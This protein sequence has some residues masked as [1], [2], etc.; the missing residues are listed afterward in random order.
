MLVGAISAVYFIAVGLS[1]SDVA[2]I[3]TFQAFIILLAD[4][5]FSYLS[6]RKS[7][8]VSILLGALFSFLWLLFMGMGSSLFE[9]YLAEFFNALSLSLF[10][11]AFIAFL[12]NTYLNNKPEASVKNIIGMYSKYHFFLMGLAALIGSLFVSVGSRNIWIF[13][14]ITMLILLIVFSFL[15][16]GENPRNKERNTTPILK[17]LK[18]IL[19]DIFS[20]RDKRLYAV[21]LLL[22]SLY[23]QIIIQFWQLF[24]NEQDRIIFEQGYIYG[25]LFVGILF[26]QSFAGYIVEKLKIEVTIKIAIIILI[27]M[28][29]LFSIIDK[30]Y[31]IFLFIVTAFFYLR[32]LMLWLQSIMHEYIPSERRATYDSIFSTLGRLLLLIALPATGYLIKIFS[33]QTVGIIFWITIVLAFFVYIGT[34]ANRT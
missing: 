19:I 1:I 28:L 10:N 15:L 6:D 11:G 13:S 18:S 16:P 12:I 33:F 9:F 20:Q 21:L 17:E 5:P 30:Q 34:L 3:K 26:A 25:I 23:Y 8:K 7:K 2:Y 24:I 27:M 29:A 4:I 31:K 32:L 22:A 14:A